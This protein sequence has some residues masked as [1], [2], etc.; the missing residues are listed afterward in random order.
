MNSEAEKAVKYR[1][2]EVQRLGGMEAYR[3][4]A[5]RNLKLKTVVKV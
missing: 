5:L 4:Q 3:L 1:E 2:E